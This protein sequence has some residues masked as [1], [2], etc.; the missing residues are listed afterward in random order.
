[1]PLPWTRRRTS[2]LAVPVSA[3]KEALAEGWTIDSPAQ[4]RQY[5]RR[6][7]GEWLY[8][9]ILWRESEVRVLTLREEPALC[10]LLAQSGVA[11]DPA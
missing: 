10:E 9:V 3:L 1:M 8:D 5:M 7:D 11:V 4:R 2:E 6:A